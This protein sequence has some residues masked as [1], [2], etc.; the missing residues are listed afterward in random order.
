M[1]MGLY[2]KNG[3]ISDQGPLSLVDTSYAPGSGIDIYI[4]YKM[5][6]WFS[7]DRQINIR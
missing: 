7:R 5:E 2:G 3:S 6:S 1:E 4:K